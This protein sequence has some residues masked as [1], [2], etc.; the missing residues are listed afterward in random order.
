[1]SAPSFHITRSTPESR[2]ALVIGLLALVALVAG[3]YWIDRNGMRIV[4]E[5]L[6]YLSLASMWNL[7]AGYAG[8]VSVGQQ[9]YVGL[10]GYFLF[11]WAILFGLPPLLAIPFAGVAG[12]IVA[13][14]VSLLVFRLKGAYFAIGTW[15][16]AEVFLLLAAQ[17]SVLGGGSGI[18][19]PISVVR[20]IAESRDGRDMAVYWSTLGV[21]VAIL[22]GI[23][24]L[25]R[26]RWG[27]ALQAIRDGELAAETSGVS[28]AT[29]KRLL[30]VVA[31]AG[32]AM[33]GAL[34]FLAKLRISP[35]AAFS[36]NDWTAFVIFIT[37][38]GGIGRI[39]GP[40]VGT[41][42]Y[43]LLRGLLADLGPTY[44]IILGAVAV[45]VM[46]FA[47]K[48]LWG[49]VADRFGWQLFPVGRRLV[50]DTSASA[51]T[52]KGA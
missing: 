39:E 4:G 18:S 40:I 48:G 47:P 27:L 37:V 43:F 35:S 28:V 42:V 29:A 32:G 51:G 26:T 22:I 12:A 46:L 13:L 14:P 34:I 36:V 15:V 19:L 2:F 31:G 7:L 1:M 17:I 50:L 8:L 25:L 49:L 38:I 20:A 45:G 23:Y 44:L 16:V 52:S 33:I 41:F 10:G 3:P 9:A 24:L 30:Y 5:F 6:I 21:A 11:A